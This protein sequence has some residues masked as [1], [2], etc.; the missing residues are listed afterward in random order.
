MQI[1]SILAPVW[2]FLSRRFALV[3]LLVVSLTFQGCSVG[4]AGLNGFSDSLDG[5]RFLYPN[6]WVQVKVTNGPDVVLHDIIEQTENM[7]V[8]IN[9][10]PGRK[11]LQDLGS[12]T[13]VGYQLGKTAIAP[14]GSGR[15]ADLVKAEERQVGDKLFYELEY[16]VT[17]K[18][19][20]QRH[21]LVSAVVSRGRLFTLNAS[22]PEVRWSVMADLLEKSVQS[23]IV[24]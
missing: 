18:D 4:L 2:K 5:Y 20:S 22:T 23:F 14:E 19:G 15:Q 3:L 9:P 6:G 24:N 1:Q 7:S 16:L 13:E 12:P 17:L 11:T 21:N 10:L 8:V